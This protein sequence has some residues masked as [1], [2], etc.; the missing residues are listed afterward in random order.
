MK[1]DI[2][3]KSRHASS[4]RPDLSGY[5]FTLR[6]VMP[7]FSPSRSDF[8]LSGYSVC[9]GGA[10]PGEDPNATPFA[11]LALLLFVLPLL[12]TLQKFV[13]DDANG[14]RSHQFAARVIYRA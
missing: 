5:I 4:V 6:T 14:D 2:T 8:T 10:E 1:R 9:Q 3:T 13:D 11:L 12:F 7:S